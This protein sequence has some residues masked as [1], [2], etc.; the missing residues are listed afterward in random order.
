[1]GSYHG[2]ATTAAQVLCTA[3]ALGQVPTIGR[4]NDQAP[5]DRREVRTSNDPFF[6]TTSAI[7]DVVSSVALRHAEPIDIGRATTAR[8]HLIGELRRWRALPANW[9]GEQARLPVQQSLKSAASF[10]CLLPEGSEAALPEPMLHASGHAGL[11]WERTGL[12]ADLE[13]L[14]D[15]RVAYYIERDG[16]KHKGVVNFSSH[17]LPT[18]FA[19]LLTA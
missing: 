14:P 17:Q 7:E 9:D 5:G 18:V 4:F 6:T 1:M 16:D 8:E 19:T 13:F 12:Y 2:T 15:G 11:F 10:A 3:L